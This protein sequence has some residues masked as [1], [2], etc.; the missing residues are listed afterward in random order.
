VPG[1]AHSLGSES[2]IQT[3]PIHRFSSVQAIGYKEI[4]MYLNGEI[5][6][7]N[8]M[9]LVKRRSRN[10]AK[11]QFT[12]FKKEEGIRW[13]DVTGMLDP[14]EIFRICLNIMPKPLLI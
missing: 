6:L 4:A 5:S 10:Y 14:Y 9:A 13:I 8:A 7:E 11:R 1:R 2:P 12:W 3:R